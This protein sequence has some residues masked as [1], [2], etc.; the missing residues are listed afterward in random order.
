[1]NAG[2]VN[3]NVSFH[4]RTTQKEWP[5]FKALTCPPSSPDPT[6]IRLLWPIRSMED[7]PRFRLG[8][9]SFGHEHRRT[10]QGVSCGIRPLSTSPLSPVGYEVG[11]SLIRL[12]PACPISARSAQDQGNL[13]VRS[14]SSTLCPVPQAIP[15]RFLLCGAHSLHVMR[16]S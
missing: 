12:G 13:E 8:S 4:S 6:S 1:M 10:L 3:R 7:S 15:K 9:A 16:P 14:T 5:Q 2:W 11:P